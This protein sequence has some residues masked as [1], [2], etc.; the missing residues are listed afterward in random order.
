MTC[1]SLHQFFTSSVLQSICSP[2]LH[3][4]ALSLST[5]TL[6]HALPDCEPPKPPRT[7]SFHPP[8]LELSWIA[9]LHLCLATTAFGLHFTPEMPSPYEIRPRGETRNNKP[10]MT[11]LKLRRLNDLNIRLQEDLERP[12]V[13]VSQA[14]KE[15]VDLAP[16]VHLMAII[17]SFDFTR[18][19]LIFFRSLINY[20]KS[21]RD[22][23]VPS[24]WGSV[25]HLPALLL[26][27]N[28]DSF[29]RT[30]LFGNRSTKGKI[31]TQ[32]NNSRWGVAILRAEE[33]AAW[34][35][36]IHFFF[37]LTLCFS[38][39]PSQAV[40][41]QSRRPPSILSRQSSEK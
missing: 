5:R 18:T 38:T 25:C 29:E 32:R 37:L 33:S 9:Y 21:T 31:P 13:T 27:L 16:S 14:S 22:Y 3:L 30:N 36:S 39:S 7:H 15:S 1:S 35:L 8:A 40:N 2:Q 34:K 28:L 11:E 20:C 19:G 10:S 6:N 41:S 17:L 26:P 24:V 23:M 12:R 4:R